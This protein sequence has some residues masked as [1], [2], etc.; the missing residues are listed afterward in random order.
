MM[1]VDIEIYDTTKDSWAQAKYLVHGI[2]DVLW[3]DN[4]D[5]ALQFLKTQVEEFKCT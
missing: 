3:T 4:L 2:D 1:I 5:Q